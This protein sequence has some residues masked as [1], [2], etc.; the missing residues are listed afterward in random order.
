MDLEELQS[1]FTHQGRSII[2]TGNGNLP[3]LTLRC[4]QSECEIYLLG[5][6]VTHFARSG[7]QPLLF[8]SSQSRWTE[9]KAIRGGIPVVF[10]WFGPNTGDSSLPAHGFARTAEWSLESVDVADES[11]AKAVFT[12]EDNEPTRA[13]W[14]HAFHLQYEVAV[15][16]R[17]ELTLTVENRSSSVFAFE[18]LLHTYIRIADIATTDLV[19]LGGTTFIDKTAGMERVVQPAD[20]LRLTGWTDRV[21]VGTEAA[22]EVHDLGAE[23]AILVTKKGSLATVVWNPWE[24]KAASLGD[25]GE[26]EWRQFVCVETANVTDHSIRLAPEEKHVMSVVYRAE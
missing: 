24:E 9:G 21:Y 12:L 8:V 4:S 10:P 2:S 5:A 18:E 14:P 6:T 15:S 7:R 19:G 26:G 17:L 20:P 11:S 22:V 3:R 13:M 25:M 23:R 1:R 16:D